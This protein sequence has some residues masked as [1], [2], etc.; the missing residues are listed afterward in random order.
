VRDEIADYQTCGVRPF[1]VNPASTTSHAG[2]AARLGLPFPLLSDPELA[3]SRAYG[4]VQP[5]GAAVARSV[6]LVDHD[7]TILHSQRGAPGAGTI[8]E[9]LRCP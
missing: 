9:G 8:L 1:G 4:A 2:Y 7:G 5:D 6:C 3:I